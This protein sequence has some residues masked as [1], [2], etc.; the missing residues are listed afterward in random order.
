MTTPAGPTRLPP[1]PPSDPME[2]RHWLVLLATVAVGASLIVY[3][4]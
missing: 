4:C 3:T 2:P 1:P